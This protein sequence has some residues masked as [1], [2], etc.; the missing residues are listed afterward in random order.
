[1]PPHESDASDEP[2]EWERRLV[3]ENACL[4]ERISHLEQAVESHAVVNQAQGILM[5]AHRISA[6]AAWAAMRRVSSHTNIK[7]RVIAD[8]VIE[9]TTRPDT[10]PESP[11]GTAALEML[12]PSLRDTDGHRRNRPDEETSPRK[13]AD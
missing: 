7:L 9:I 4:K 13:R 12:L 8:A 5:A 6:D 11:A 2:P 3:E 1:M 10:V